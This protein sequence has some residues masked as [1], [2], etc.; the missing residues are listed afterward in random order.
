ME[1]C[2]GVAGPCVTCNF[3]R[4]RAAS[5]HSRSRRAQHRRQLPVG[6]GLHQKAACGDEARLALCCGTS[7]AAMARRAM[8]PQRGPWT[9]SNG[10]GRLRPLHPECIAEV[11][12]AQKALAEGGQ[13]GTFAAGRP[14]PCIEGIPRVGRPTARSV[15]SGDRRHWGGI[16]RSQG[17]TS[18]HSRTHHPP[19]D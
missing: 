2:A 7:A 9:R 3:G 18:L 11:R 10:L 16:A 4:R 8:Q 15:A 1:T 5:D 13:L 14:A 12:A 19:R 17:R 6:V